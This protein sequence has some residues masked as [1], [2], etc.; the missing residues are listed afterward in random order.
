MVLTS[1]GMAMDYTIKCESAR[2][3]GVGFIHRL[4]ECQTIE[5]V[6]TLRAI[7][8]ITW[9]AVKVDRS[10]ITD[11]LEKRIDQRRKEIKGEMA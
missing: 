2:D 3:W 10:D 4:K 8:S 11:H 6:E 7:H 9:D 5:H 1:G